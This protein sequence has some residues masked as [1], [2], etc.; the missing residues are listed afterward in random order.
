MSFASPVFLWYFLP[1]VVAAY[2]LLPVRGRNALLL[3]SSLLFYAWGGGV[4]VLLLAT[5]IAANYAA[6]LAISSRPHDDERGRNV[7][8]GLAVAGNLS[9]LAVWKYT[10]FVVTQLNGV[11]GA[12]AGPRL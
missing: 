3:A 6:G 8:L 1:A 11:A 7:L 12:L 9:M 10:S 5:Y 2:L 4:F